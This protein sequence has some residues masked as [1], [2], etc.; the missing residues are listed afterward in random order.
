[1]LAVITFLYLF[2]LTP[3]NINNPCR[4]YNMVKRTEKGITLPLWKCYV[5][6]VEEQVANPTTDA[7][8]NFMETQ[9]DDT[10]KALP[11]LMA[12]LENGIITKTTKQRLQELEAM[13]EKLEYEIESYKQRA[14]ELNERQIKLLEQMRQRSDKPDD[15]YRERLLDCFVNSVYLYEDKAIVSFNLTKEKATLESVTLSLLHD[16]LPD[17]GDDVK[18]SC[19]ALCGGDERIKNEPI[20]YYNRALLLMLSIQPAR[21]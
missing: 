2:M 5:F 12:A 21:K 4:N 11:N 8:L 9:L 17:D 3:Y 19:S 6:M 20:Y 18:G 14:P 16:T 13:Q 10:K 7:E 15:E 1:M